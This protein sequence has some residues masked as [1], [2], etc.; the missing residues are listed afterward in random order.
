MFL[1]RLQTKTFS[2]CHR[3]LRD[4]IF[5]SEDDMS[6]QCEHV[7]SAEWILRIDSLHADLVML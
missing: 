1:K 7:S 2:T 6:M 4:V 3:F 5:Y